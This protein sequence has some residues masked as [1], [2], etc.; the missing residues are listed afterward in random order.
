M[1]QNIAIS[2]LPCDFAAF[3]MQ[4][5]SYTI[6]CIVILFSSITLLS[7]I[8]ANYYIVLMQLTALIYLSLNWSIL[9]YFNRSFFVI[10]VKRV[11]FFIFYCQKAT[12]Y[13]IFKEVMIVREYEFNEPWG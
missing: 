2:T 13:E 5:N 10:Y 8:L 3:T 7:S 9:F 1:I 4:L 12:V 6:K 11:M